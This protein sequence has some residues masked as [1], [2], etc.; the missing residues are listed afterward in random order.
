MFVNPG[1]TVILEEFC[2]AGAINRFKRVGANIVGVPLDEDGMR[3]DVLA[4]TLEGLKQKGVTP[5]Y[6]YT[7]PDH[8][9]SV[10]QHPAVGAPPADAG[11]RAAVRRADLRGRM[12][13][14]SD[15]GRRCAAGAVCDGSEAGR[16]YRL[17]LQDARAGAARR[18]RG[19]RVAGAVAHDRLQDRQRHRR[20][21]SD[22]RRR[23]L[24]QVLRQ[25]CRRA[26]R[27]AEGEARH[28]GGGGGARVRHHRRHVEAEG[29]HLPVVEAAG[30]RSM[31]GSW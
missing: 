16:A 24:L 6:I 31:C 1:D 30:Q 26:D 12:L 20:A 23:V 4:S 10:R 7:I 3:M 9:E 15:L 11:A 14:R 29:R 17:V 2:Y 8:P 27:R 18:L 5:K 28:H 19:G 25:A 13:R 21:R 22:D